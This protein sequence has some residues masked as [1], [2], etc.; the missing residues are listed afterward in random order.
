MFTYLYVHIYVHIYISNYSFSILC[1]KY[2]CCNVM[3]Y[4][5]FEL[6][7]QILITCV[8][9]KNTQFNL[10]ASLWPSISNK[11]SYV[12]NSLMCAF[13]SLILWVH[14]RMHV[15]MCVRCVGMCIG[16]VMNPT[17]FTLWAQGLD[18]R[19]LGMEAINLT[20]ISMATFLCFIITSI[21]LNL[22][23]W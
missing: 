16:T 2:L 18:L 15:C 14:V 10:I 8:S 12:C 4:I 23:V 6:H 11:Y 13:L 20:I 22:L 5:F 7:I 1:K 17:P 9:E 21:N 3:F 19:F